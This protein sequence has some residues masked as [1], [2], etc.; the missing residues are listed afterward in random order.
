MIEIIPAIDL[1]DGQCVR[2]RRGDYGQVTRYSS[3]P[4]AVASSFRDAGITRLHLVDLD[5]A[6]SG[7]P[8]NLSVLERIAAHTSLRIEFGGGIKS[9]QSVADVLGAGAAHVIIGS[10]AVKQP[11][12]MD[13]WLAE[14]GPERVILGAD[15]R[16][17]LVSV[18]GWL[19]DSSLSVADVFNRF[20]PSGLSQAIV[21]EI[22]RDGMLAGPDFNLYS[23][24]KD[25]FPAVCLTASGGVT[26]MA[27]IARL[28]SLGIERAIV[29][30]ALYEGRISLTDISRFISQA[31]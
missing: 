31:I 18:S 13:R 2:L 23:G 14:Y 21:T 3:D 7:A 24:L 5:G 9:S 12:L 6:K 26:T 30:K 29:G 27:D 4:L 20:I 11:A 22:S 15:I 16:G 28:Q 8:C 10:A 1:I 19:E 17:G 25:R